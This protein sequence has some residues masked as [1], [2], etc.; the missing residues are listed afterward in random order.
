[1]PR[2]TASPRARASVSTG[3]LSALLIALG[4]NAALADPPIHSAEDA[5]CRLEAKARVFVTP[6]PRGLEPEA[7]G[8]QLYYACMRRLTRPA[9]QPRGRAGHRRHRRHRRY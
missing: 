7:I 1:M 9:M 6:N 2:T 5:A 3:L 8:R 4:G